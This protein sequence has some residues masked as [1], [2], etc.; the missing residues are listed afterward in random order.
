M[1]RPVAPRSRFPHFRE[2]TL[3]Y[4][5]CQNYTATQCW[6]L[7]QMGRHATRRRRRGDLGQLPEDQG[8]VAKASAVC[9]QDFPRKDS[10][11]VIV[12]H[13]SFRT[14]CGITFGRLGNQESVAKAAGAVPFRA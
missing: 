7:R 13:N 1:A 9:G 12:G 8:K 2:D 6:S 3:S 5:P 11:T 4:P 14:D 10:M